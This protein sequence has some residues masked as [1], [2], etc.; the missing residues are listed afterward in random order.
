MKYD[1]VQIRIPPDKQH[2]GVE[3]Y[4]TE[5][6]LAEEILQEIQPFTTNNAKF[7]SFTARVD[8]V[9]TGTF[10]SLMQ[11]DSA[12]GW[13]IVKIVSEKGWDFFLACVDAD[14]SSFFF[15]HTRHAMDEHH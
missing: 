6:K 9:T 4:S 11:K 10:T 12:I 2:N 8:T 5:T 14:F 13:L 15:K 7:E 3:F 1:I